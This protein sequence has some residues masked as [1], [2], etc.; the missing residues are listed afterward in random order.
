MQAICDHGALCV[1]N[2]CACVP[3]T[4]AH[5]GR[6]V[7]YVPPQRQVGEYESRLSPLSKHATLPGPGHLCNN[8]EHCAFGS[9]CDP[10]IPVCVCPPGT[11]LN[12]GRCEQVRTTLAALN[13]FNT[14][15]TQPFAKYAPAAASALPNAGEKP[16]VVYPQ[17][18][19][20][21]STAQ[22]AIAQS[23]LLSLP[24]PT[25]PSTLVQPSFAT[26]ASIAQAASSPRAPNP[27]Q[28]TSERRLTVGSACTLKY[29]SIKVKYGPNDRFR[30]RA[31]RRSS[32]TALRAWHIV[33]FGGHRLAR[34][35]LPLN[36]GATASATTSATTSFCIYV[37]R[38]FSLRHMQKLRPNAKPRKFA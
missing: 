11:D 26:A 9:V 31:I 37:W 23:Q 13:P 21:E 2:I 8:G 10:K 22:Q 15:P 3:P 29:V 35:A 7:E 12:N 36:L 18:R 17:M 5:R 1:N 25:P 38:A 6:C 34:M 33:R 20:L 27:F 28:L 19:P 32:S 30:T 14:K 24:L 16:I 4:I